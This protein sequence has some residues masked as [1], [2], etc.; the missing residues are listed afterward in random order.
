MVVLAVLSAAVW[1]ASHAAAEGALIAG[2]IVVFAVFCIGRAIS[3]RRHL[4]KS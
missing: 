1:G 4:P 3:E 2:F